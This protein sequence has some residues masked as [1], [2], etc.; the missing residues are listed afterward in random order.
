MQSNC[1]T[2]ARKTHVTP[3][4][5]IGG[6]FNEDEDDEY[7][8]NRRSWVRCWFRRFPTRSKKID[9]I[10]RISF[11]AMFALFNVVYWFTYLYRDEYTDLESGA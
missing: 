1:L 3:F 4:N 10:S 6:E 8:R 7:N 9:V 5:E 2:F 11:P